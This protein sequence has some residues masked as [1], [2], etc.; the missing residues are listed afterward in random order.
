MVKIPMYGSVEQLERN[1]D[2]T[3]MRIKGLVKFDNKDNAYE[4]QGVG[5]TFELR[6]SNLPKSSVECSKILVIGKHLSL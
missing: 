3:V 6:E 4:L 5:D 1:I 2:V